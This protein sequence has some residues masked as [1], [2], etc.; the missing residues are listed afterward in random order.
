MCIKVILLYMQKALLKISP[1]RWTEKLYFLIL[2]LNA[3]ISYPSTLPEN[4]DAS[5]YPLVNILYF[6]VKSK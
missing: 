6:V 1:I 5:F 3:L 2:K 4:Y